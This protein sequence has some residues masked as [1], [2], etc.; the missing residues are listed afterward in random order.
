MKREFLTQR[1]QSL[2]EGIPG[3]ISVDQAFAQLTGADDDHDNDETDDNGDNDGTSD[4]GPL[5]PDDVWDLLKGN[6][7]KTPT[8][9]ETPAWWAVSG[10]VPANKKGFWAIMLHV[11]GTKEKAVAEVN[12]FCSGLGKSFRL[13]SLRQLTATEKPDQNRII[14]NIQKLKIKKS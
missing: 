6:E 2:R 1:R 8:Q 12:T 9:S 10:N 11:N 13:T 3:R 7:G 5:T 4:D 14:E